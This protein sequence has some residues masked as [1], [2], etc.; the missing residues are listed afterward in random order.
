MP[1]FAQNAKY[2]CIY[3]NL[4]VILQC[5]V[6]QGYYTPAN[7]ENKTKARPIKET[8]TLYGEDARRFAISYKRNNNY[9]SSLQDA[10]PEKVTYK[11]TT[12]PPMA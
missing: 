4:F 6:K 7:T 10:K 11:I 9:P 1:N 8:P 2:I 3:Q 12:L 5:Q